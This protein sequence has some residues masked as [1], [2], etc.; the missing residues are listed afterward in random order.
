MTNKRLKIPPTKSVLLSLK[1]KIAFLEQGHTLLERKK[2]LLTRLVYERLKQYRELR[3]EAKTQV[4][5]AYHW[6]GITHMRMSNQT[7]K[8]VSIGLPPPV[9]I[10]ILPRSSIGVQYPAVTAERKPL[11]PVGLMGTD[12]SFDETRKHF[13]DMVV[14]LAKLG[15]AE[16]ALWRLL[17]EQRKTQKRVNALKYNIIPTYHAT[18]QFIKSSLEEEERNT[19]FQIQRLRENAKQQEAV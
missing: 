14:I 15:E 11:E 12:S 10:Q 17:E 16:T 18:I 2:E 4:E 19:L 3:K 8:Q 13:A 7:L 1:R 9:D 6:L 5:Q